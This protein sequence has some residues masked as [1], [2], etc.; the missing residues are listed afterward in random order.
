MRQNNKKTLIFSLVN[1][2]RSLSPKLTFRRI[3]KQTLLSI[4]VFIKG[5]LGFSFWFTVFVCNTFSYTHNFFAPHS[6]LPPF[7][8]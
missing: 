5:A 3:G 8:N 7:L 2:Y 4:S 1:V 6:V